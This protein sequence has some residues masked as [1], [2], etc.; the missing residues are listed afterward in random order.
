M[1]LKEQLIYTFD[2]LPVEKQ[3]EAI[4]F[5][6]YLNSRQSASEHLFSTEANTKHLN[7]AIE[8]IERGENLITV[9]LDDL[10][11]GIFPSI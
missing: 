10:R 7:E 5:I 8:E 4:D 3:E 11:K 6:E 9:N 2:Q 1:N